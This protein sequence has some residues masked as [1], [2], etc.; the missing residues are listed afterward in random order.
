MKLVT[1]EVNGKSSYGA[2][3][4]DRI[5][6]LGRSFSNKYADMRAVLENDALPALAKPPLSQWAM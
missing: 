2:A 6:D 4:G 1:F 3:K 5:V